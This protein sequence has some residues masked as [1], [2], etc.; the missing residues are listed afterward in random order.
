MDPGS[1]LVLAGPSG[2]GKSTL[3]GVLLGLVVPTAGTVRVGDLNLAKLDPDTWRS[4]LAWDP[5]VRTCLPLPLP[6]TS[7][8][9]AATLPT[10]RSVRRRPTPGWT[11]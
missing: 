4:S 6:T 2:C 7:V 5:S 8:L 9:A 11:P 10:R 1:V 3:L